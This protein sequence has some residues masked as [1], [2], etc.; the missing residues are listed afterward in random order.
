MFNND[1]I[2][3][4]SYIPYYPKQKNCLHH[5]LLIEKYKKIKSNL[6]L[7][8]ANVKLINFDLINHE[9]RG[10]PLLHSLQYYQQ[11]RQQHFENILNEDQ[12]NFVSSA[13][14]ANRNDIS[15]YRNVI[16]DHFVNPEIK[17]KFKEKGIFLSAMESKAH[18][19][20]LN[21]RYSAC[22]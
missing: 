7:Y 8:F 12:Y 17:Q 16:Q 18:K 14:K 6:P 1:K 4:D 9:L 20:R 19:K 21:Q 13:I 2:I 3:V 15:I 5:T 11:I 10:T 22:W